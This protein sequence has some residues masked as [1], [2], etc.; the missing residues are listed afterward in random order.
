MKDKVEKV[1]SRSLL[2][3]DSEVALLKSFKVVHAIVSKK[4]KTV[5]LLFSFGHI[6][7]MNC[8]S[9]CSKANPSWPSLQWNTP[10]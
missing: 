2:P 8:T 9:S 1:L 6:V 10:V 3:C 4:I 7:V 5:F